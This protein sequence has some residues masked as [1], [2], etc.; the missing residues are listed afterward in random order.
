VAE[1]AATLSLCDPL[2]RSLCSTLLDRR[3][4][5]LVGERFAGSPIPCGRRR[6][7]CAGLARM[8][9]GRNT[10]TKPDFCRFREGLTARPASDRR[11]HA[12]LGRNTRTIRSVTRPSSKCTGGQS[13][14][15]RPRVR[16][17]RVRISTPRRACSRRQR[18]GE[19]IAVRPR[20][21]W[22]PHSCRDQN[23]TVRAA[24]RADQN[25]SGSAA[26]P[27]PSE[28]ES[29]AAGAWASFA[30][31]GKSF[32]RSARKSRFPMSLGPAIL[33]AQAA[34]RPSGDPPLR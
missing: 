20:L 21:P 29:L 31:W 16:E 32:R 15:H 12:R 23:P 6:R 2:A 3:K 26:G 33:P 30:R 13:N 17:W 8:R 28:V 11:S 34:T 7:A 19:W 24:G 25:S 14:V 18:P 5:Q 1:E 22:Q 10:L 4:E 27:G 9:V